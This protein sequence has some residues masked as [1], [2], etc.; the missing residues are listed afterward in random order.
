MLFLTMHGIDSDHRTGQRKR[1]EQSLDRRDFIGLFVAVEMRQHQ[2]RVRS[3][4]A[5]YVRGARRSRKLSKLRSKVLS[6]IA[7]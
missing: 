6:S 5:K 4:G 1:A 2:S 3:E 7:T